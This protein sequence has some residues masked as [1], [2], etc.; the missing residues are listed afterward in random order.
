[1]RI[2]SLLAGW[3]LLW[4]SLPFN[5]V[6]APLAPEVE[7][8]RNLLRD[9]K[10]EDAVDAGE[11]AIERHEGDALAWLW[12][13]RAYGRQTMQ[14]NMLMKPKWAGRTRDAFERAV[15][16]DPGLVDARFD[17]M[18]YYL[19]APS[20]VGGGRD[21]ADEQIA[22]I[23]GLDPSMGDLAR[24]LVA[25]QDEQSQLAEQSFRSALARNPDNGRARMSLSNLLQSE[26]RMTDTHALWSER[27]AAKP[28]DLMAVYQLGRHAALTGEN[29]E[30]GLAHLDAFITADVLPEGLSVAGAH[31]RRGQILEK[32]GRDDLALQAYQ[33]AIRDDSVGELARADHERLSERLRG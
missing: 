4:M 13:G 6:A 11:A 28:D 20:I 12:A 3:S 15:A 25:Q 10:V 23:A 1:M 18:Q 33:W 8:V 27:H 22:A 19:M 5:V 24:G 26:Q 29:L 32:L 7:E 31:W 9:G 2:A 17:L 30:A 14:A 21:K 16:L